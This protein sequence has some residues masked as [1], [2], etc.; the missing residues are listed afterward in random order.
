M[1]NAVTPKMKPKQ[2]VIVGIT[3]FAIMIEQ[4]GSK[5][6]WFLAREEYSWRV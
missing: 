2:L 1:V 3:G 6:R 5:L 4:F